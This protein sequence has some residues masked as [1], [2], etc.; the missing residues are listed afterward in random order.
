MRSVLAAHAGQRDV[1]Y[2]LRDA[3]ESTTSKR[4]CSWWISGAPAPDFP[5]GSA[6][7]WT[8]RALSVSGGTHEGRGSRSPRHVSCAR[9]ER[10]PPG[11]A[12]RD[13][14]YRTLG[15]RSAAR[16]EVPALLSRAT[17][18]ILTEGQHQGER[19]WGA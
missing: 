2:R 5:I 10:R 18:P 4:S 7:C 15:R 9:A 14:L 6:C 12:P 3:T 16:A 1:R 8:Q 13:D 11:Y 17:D 19:S